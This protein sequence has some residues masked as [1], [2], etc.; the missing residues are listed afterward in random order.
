MKHDETLVNALFFY[1]KKYVAHSLRIIVIFSNYNG[2]SSL[3]YYD[4]DI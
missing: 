2:V 1:I 4:Y 3:N